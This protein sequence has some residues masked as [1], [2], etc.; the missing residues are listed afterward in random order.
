MMIEES[1]LTELEKLKNIKEQFRR[2]EMGNQE[3]GM[4]GLGDTVRQLMSEMTMLET[5]IDDL[6]RQLQ[7]RKSAL[8]QCFARWQDA[9]RETLP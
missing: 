7:E 4:L 6:E 1:G 9:I 2:R 5:E 8:K 3:Q